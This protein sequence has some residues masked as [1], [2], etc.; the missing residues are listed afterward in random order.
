MSTQSEEIT[1]QDSAWKF[2]ATCRQPHWWGRHLIGP[3][4]LKRLHD[5]STTLDRIRAHFQHGAN[6]ETW[7]PG[8]P[9]DEAV[10]KVIA[11]R[12]AMLA[13]LE[14]IDD[15]ARFKKHMREHYAAL[16]TNDNP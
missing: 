1:A 6:E 16:M 11:E 12:D 7:P 9:I 5:D 10:G 13:R 8:T 2:I 15:D 14:E 4:A 3:V